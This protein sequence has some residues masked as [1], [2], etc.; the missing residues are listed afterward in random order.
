MERDQAMMV[1]RAPWPIRDFDHDF[2]K[3][4]GVDFD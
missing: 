1:P 2:G 4:L 3:Q